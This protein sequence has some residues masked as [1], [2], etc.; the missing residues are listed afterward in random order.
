MSAFTLQL[1]HPKK[2]D[3]KSKVINI[4]IKIICII[5]YCCAYRQYRHQGKVYITAL[6]SQKSL[7]IFRVWNHNCITL[8]GE[9]QTPWEKDR[10]SITFYCWLSFIAL[11]YLREKKTI[12]AFKV[13]IFHF[14][15][16]QNDTLKA[17][18]SNKSKQTVFLSCNIIRGGQQQLHVFKPTIGNTFFFLL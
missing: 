6:R 10:Y 17:S 18:R 3:P 7:A 15:Q 1:F 8:F 14:A 12:R 5:F 9:M 13:L 11:L 2:V 4:C 16:H